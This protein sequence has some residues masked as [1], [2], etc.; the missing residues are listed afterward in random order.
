M[1]PTDALITESLEASINLEFNKKLLIK[2]ADV[3]TIAQKAFKKYAEWQRNV[4]GYDK[5]YKRMEPWTYY[6]SK[7]QANK[8]ATDALNA[9]RRLI[10]AYRKLL[11][12]VYTEKN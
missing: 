10:K 5:A 3:L 2:A 9:Y 1:T 11:F 12:Q 4:I 6:T 8:K 7:E